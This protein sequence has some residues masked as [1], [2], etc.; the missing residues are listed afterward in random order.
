MMDLL[1]TTDGQKIKYLRYKYIGWRHQ[2]REQ[3]GNNNC[4]CVNGVKNKAEPLLAIYLRSIA[5]LNYNIFNIY[6]GIALS[7]LH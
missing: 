6:L 2:T 3:T 4:H 5:S 1:P 7:E